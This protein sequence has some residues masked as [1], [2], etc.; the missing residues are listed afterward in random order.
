MAPREP[1][2]CETGLP[3][4]A[5]G[6]G[7]P[8][9]GA[10][11]T[12]GIPTGGAPGSA[13]AATAL[14][15]C[16]G[17]M[18]GTWCV[19]TFFP[20]DATEP[21]FTNIWSDGPTDAWAVGAGF[22][23]ATGRNDGNGVAIHWDGCTWAPSSLAPAAGLLDIWGASAND[24]WTVGGAGTALHWNGSAWSPTITG[25]TIDLTSVSGTASNDVWALGFGISLHWNGSSWSTVP[26]FPSNPAFQGFDG[27][28]WAVAPNDVWAALGLPD[29]LAHFDGTGWTQIATAAYPGFG[30]FGIWAN[31]TTGWAV[32]EGRQIMQ[33]SGGTWTLV[34]AP[35]GSSEG[36]LNVMGLGAC[37]SVSLHVEEALRAAARRARAS[38]PPDSCMIWRPSPTAQPVVQAPSE[39]LRGL[40]QRDGAGRRRLD[41]RSG[42]RRSASAGARFSRSPTV[43]MGTYSGLWL[44]PS[45]IW[46]AGDDFAS[47]AVI[48]HRAR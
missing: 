7:Q 45:Q 15:N 47:G 24:V 46:L 35:S 22:N 29:G 18:V 33:L 14:T 12:S 34:Q 43:P 17:T 13:C 5:G 20:N 41:R 37:T 26:G 48:L 38:G 28:V 27:D 32:G 3:T 23:P 40:P 8:T 6:A 25:T 30:F 10:G 42:H 39:Q 9:G 44:T 36:F 16:N 11:G 21:S 2:T 31:G 4:G 19:D 1:A